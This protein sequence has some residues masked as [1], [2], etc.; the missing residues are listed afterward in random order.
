MSETENSR[1]KRFGGREWTKA[2]PSLV[3]EPNLGAVRSALDNDWVFGLH[4]IYY[5]A[6]S[7][8]VVA[9]R[10]W[11]EY[12]EHVLAS[13]AGDRFILW[14]LDRLRNGGKLL[15]E[16]RS[17]QSGDETSIINALTASSEYLSQRARTG[18]IR[19]AIALTLP[20]GA[21]KIAHLF[22]DY[23]L[24]EDLPGFLRSANGPGGRWC[25]VPF[26]DIDPAVEPRHLE[27][28]LVDAKRPDEYGA[29]PVGGCY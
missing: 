27:Y 28:V 29:V 8:E 4:L 16:K 17:D 19:E 1:L 23:D 2:I 5:G 14:P 12:F 20:S 21:D 11:E 3:D 24:S 25:I 18:E 26:T 9:F 13:R 22:N 6:T 15:A 7:P 10:V